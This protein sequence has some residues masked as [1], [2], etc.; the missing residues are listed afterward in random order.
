MQHGNL[1]TTTKRYI[2]MAEKYAAAETTA[3]IFVPD[4]LQG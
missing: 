4:V 2:N 1:G 3:K